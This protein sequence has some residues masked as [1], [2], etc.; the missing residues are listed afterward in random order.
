M[1]DQQIVLLEEVCQKIYNTHDATER[2]N[3]EQVNNIWLTNFGTNRVYQYYVQD[4]R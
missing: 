4:D 3:A 2:K 1:N